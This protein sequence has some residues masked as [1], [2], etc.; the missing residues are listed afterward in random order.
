MKDVIVGMALGVLAQGVE[1]VARNKME[2]E[3]AF[4]HAWT[5]AAGK[6]VPEHQGT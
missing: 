4:N 1:A 2:F 6:S 5:L 3:F